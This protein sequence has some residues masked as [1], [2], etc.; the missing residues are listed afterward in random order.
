MFQNCFESKNPSIA[1]PQKS[2][3]FLSPC[4]DSSNGTDSQSAVACRLKLNFSGFF[5][6]QIKPSHFTG[7]AINSECL[8]ISPSDSSTIP[9]HFLC[10]E[11][12]FDI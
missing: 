9:L 2:I 5:P 12:S 1:K 3:S 7:T 8:F 4:R 6:P 11:F 10:D